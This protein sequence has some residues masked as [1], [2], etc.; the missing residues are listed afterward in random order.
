MKPWIK[1]PP[2]KKRGE[3]IFTVI[4]LFALENKQTNK[5]TSF[6][7]VTVLWAKFSWTPHTKELSQLGLLIVYIPSWGFWGRSHNPFLNIQLLP[8]NLLSATLPWSHVASRSDKRTWP[9]KTKGEDPSVQHQGIPHP[10]W[11]RS[12]PVLP[13]REEN[14][15]PCEEPLTHAL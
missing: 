11:A 6:W 15:H 9:G 4:M 14:W 13:L 10:W 7:C 8:T 5:Q 3:T 12:S 1:S 2:T